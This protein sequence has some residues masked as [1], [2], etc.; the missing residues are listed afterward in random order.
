MPYIR[1]TASAAAAVAV[2]LALAL[3]PATARPCDHGD[4]GCVVSPQA[5][6]IGAQ[7][8]PMKLDQFI[9]TW[10]PVAKRHPVATSGKSKKSKST[11]KPAAKEV[12]PE[13]AVAET[14]PA[15][16]P[17]ETIAAN[18]DQSVATD[19]VGITPFDEANEVDAAD[20]T[21]PS[22]VQVVAFNEV[23]ELDLAAPSPPVPPAS[24]GQSVFA[25][26]PDED[27]S[28]RA[29]LLLAI[30][31]TIALAGATRFFVA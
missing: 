25:E 1:L 22:N 29:K 9:K 19:A 16:V 11:R 14:A 13:P 18:P 8:D 12:A 15:P 6:A 26:Q 28:W 5:D 4:A 3:S 24:V 31:G 27:N 17:T 23:N 20:S 10:K 2:V 30:A 7:A 21:P